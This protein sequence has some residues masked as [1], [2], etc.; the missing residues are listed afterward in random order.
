MPIV[1]ACVRGGSDAH[2]GEEAC[3]GQLYHD[4]LV[5]DQDRFFVHRQY[6]L[7]SSVSEA[8]VPVFKM[9]RSF[10]GVEALELSDQLLLKFVTP[11]LGHVFRV[12]AQHYPYLVV[13]DRICQLLHPGAAPITEEG[14]ECVGVEN[15]MA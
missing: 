3:V 12:D 1:I 9:G 7:R 5:L 2:E 8:R 10:L 4:S 14:V 11:D 15:G 6:G 13:G